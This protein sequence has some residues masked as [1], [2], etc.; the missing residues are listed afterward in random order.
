MIRIALLTLLLLPLKASVSEA[1]DK[2]F[3]AFGDSNTVGHGDT[4]V[5]CPDPVITGGY[6]TR[7]RSR[8]AARGIDAEF[9]NF[10]L[11]GERTTTGITRIES[12]LDVG[13]DVIVIMEGTNDISRG[14]GLET[15]LF[16]LGEMARK[17][18]AA[19]V[20]PLLAS[21]IPQGP[22]GDDPNNILT[23]VLAV[24]LAAAALA[25]G[26]VFADPFHAFFNLPNFFARY[27][28]D[29]LHPTPAGYGVLADSLVDAAVEAATRNDLCAQVPPGPCVAGDTVLCLNQGR[30]R[31]EV[32]WENFF[33]QTG[34]GR[35][36]PQTEDTGAF[37]WVDPRNIELTVKVLDGR[38]YNGHF[39]VFY[40]ALSNL[41]FSVAVTDTVTGACKEYFNPLGTFASVG[42]TEAF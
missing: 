5:L 40:G 4:G 36:V 24:R 33:G 11:C 35:A 32:V 17:A 3:L 26:R 6:P 19:G 18:E 30:F 16:N 10:G 34:V 42:D 7:L 27:Y 20:E 37:F 2:R 25:E 14:I 23:E 9:L 12:V 28:F 13:G 21:V 15:I 38:H 41:E 31:L 39:W 8:L 29:Q 22:E 1:A